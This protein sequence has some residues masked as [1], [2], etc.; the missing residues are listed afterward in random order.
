MVWWI[1][2]ECVG[3]A[4]TLAY[5]ESLRGFTVLNEALDER[6]WK[7]KEHAWRK[8]MSWKEVEEAKEEV[9]IVKHRTA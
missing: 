1:T 5:I 7:R 4:S 6:T 8:R 3:D 9:R 2:R